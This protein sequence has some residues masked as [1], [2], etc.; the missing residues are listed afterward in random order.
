MTIMPFFLPKFIIQCE[1]CGF[2]KPR[3]INLLNVFLPGGI[4][5][6]P[7]VLRGAGR[8]PHCGGKMKVTKL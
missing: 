2:T 1:K 5:I 8:C 4:Q 7:Y 6:L 3:K